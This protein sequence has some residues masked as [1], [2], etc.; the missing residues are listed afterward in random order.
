MARLKVHGKI[1]G[2]KCGAPITIIAYRSTQAHGTGWQP[3]PTV[4]SWDPNSN[5]DC[6]M[7][8][9]T[10]SQAGRQVGRQAGRQAG[11]QAGRQ[12]GKQA[13]RQAGRQETSDFGTINGKCFRQL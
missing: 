5:V 9:F 13:S 8:V 12:T 1:Q 7:A 6:A 11:K 3:Q 2:I 4:R 10:S